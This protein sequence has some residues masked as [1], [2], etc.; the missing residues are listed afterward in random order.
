MPVK[1]ACA[2]IFLYTVFASLLL[3]QLKSLPQV[4]AIIIEIMS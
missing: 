3:S 4:P 2:G 1:L